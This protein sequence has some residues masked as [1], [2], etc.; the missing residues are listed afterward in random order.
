M[1]RASS[2]G[3]S[4]PSSNI[5]V[6]QQCRRLS[7]ARSRWA[8]FLGPL[9]RSSHSTSNSTA[10]PSQPSSTLDREFEEELLASKPERGALNNSNAVRLP[11]SRE[12]PPR[13][14]NTTETRPVS[15]ARFQTEAL[16]PIIVAEEKL[17]HTTESKNKHTN[18]SKTHHVLPLHYAKVDAAIE[19]LQKRAENPTYQPNYPLDVFWEKTGLDPALE[20]DIWMNLKKMGTTDSVDEGWDAYLYLVDVIHQNPVVQEQLFPHIKFAHLHRLCRLLA[21]NVP[22]THRQYLRLLSVMTYINY[23]GGPLQQFEFTALIDNAGKGWRRVHREDFAHARDVYNDLMQGR[24]PSIS[25]DLPQEYSTLRGVTFEPDVYSLSS[26]ASQ[27]AR[28]LDL[29][30]MRGVFK[31]FEKHGVV[32]NR[33][34]YLSQLKYYID[35]RD[36]AGLRMSLQRMRSLNLEIGIEGLNH[37]MD[38][39]SRLGRVEV[40][41]MIYR[42]LRHNLTPETWEYGDEDEIDDVAAQLGE[43][44]IF[45]EA[46]LVP[47]QITYRT[48]IQVMSY[49]GHF[50]LALEALLDMLSPAVESNGVVSEPGL[51][52]YRSL[53]LGFSRHAAPSS[54]Q[55]DSGWTLVNLREIFMKF[56]ELPSDTQINHFTL[57]SIMTAFDKCT[58]HDDAELRIIWRRIHAAFDVTPIKPNSLSTTAMLKRRL[59]P[60]ES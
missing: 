8:P 6:V 59:F 52:E 12:K 18:G 43:E 44:Y 10:H 3:L 20:L 28:S 48:A 19:V 26:L 57:Q 34:T 32:P 15:S 40:S 36:L 22:K 29:S 46:D 31:A 11:F 58:D 21:T 5:F 2:L 7:G 13:V 4:F 39:Y 24:L 56:L 37:C 41:I 51:V 25:A 55:S 30:A 38:G 9:R 33:I 50:Y 49:H 47:D 42:L 23:Y 1:L 17:S 14:E 60:E 27:A 54:M 16:R 45:V 53:F 35:K